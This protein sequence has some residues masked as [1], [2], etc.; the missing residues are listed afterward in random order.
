MR[1]LGTLGGPDAFAFYI[2][3]RGEIAGQSYTN[4]TANPVLDPCGNY[5]IN[6]PTQDPFL[7]RKGRMIDIGTLGGTCGSPNGLNNQGD[8]VGQ[9]DVLGDQSFH[10]FLWR[11]G[12]IQPMR[13]R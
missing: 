4:S 5:A 2:N 10:A 8:V 9:S 12:K 7:W 3:D 6:V 13:V 1:D 11:N